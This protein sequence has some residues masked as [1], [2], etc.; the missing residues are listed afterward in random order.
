MNRK[1]DPATIKN[2]VISFANSLAGEGTEGL[3]YI[4]K[5]R[6]RLSGELVRGGQVVVRVERMGIWS[7]KYIIDVSPGADMAL[8]VGI[9]AA[10]EDKIRNE[11]SAT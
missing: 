1:S 9:V 7:N 4:Q 5:H 11:S 8:V 2:N 10:V 6:G 3:E